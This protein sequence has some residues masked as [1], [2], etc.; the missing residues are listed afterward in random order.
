MAPARSERTLVAVSFAAVVLI[1]SSTYLG[2]RIALEGFPP[3]A[4]GAI[5]F[6]VAGSLLFAYLRARGERAP[7]AREWGAAAL[8]GGLFFVLGNGLVNVAE[9][10]VSSGLTSV[11]VATMPLW[12]TLLERFTGG[13]T[14]AREWAGIGLGLAGVIV[15]NLGGEMRATGMG[16]ACALVAPMAW[17]LGSIVGKRLPLPGGAMRTA[18]QMLAGGALMAIVSVAMGEHVRAAPAARTIG[19]LAYL[20]IF[21]SL[22]AFSA[23]NYLLKHTRMAFATSYAYVNPILAV[24]LGVGFAGERLD[25]MGAIGAVTVL[26]AVLMITRAPRAPAAPAEP[27]DR[28]GIADVADP[29]AVDVSLLRR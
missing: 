18:A 6:L 12:A 26:A 3:F 4:I 22:A 1:W 9:E 29:V 16:A 11:L 28:A 5:R 23:Y 21:G 25:A 14:S 15:L 8:T 13:R 24:A 10:R 7:T 2:I 19:A 17:A 27:S 20:A